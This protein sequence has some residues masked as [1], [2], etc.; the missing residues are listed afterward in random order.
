MLRSQMFWLGVGCSL[1][2]SLMCSG[3]GLL[4]MIGSGGSLAEHTVRRWGLVGRGRSLGP[5]PG[6]S[7]LP[8]CPALLSPLPGHHDMSNMIWATF[9]RQTFPLCISCLEPTDDRLGMRA[10]T[11]L[12]SNFLLSG[13]VLW[14]KEWLKQRIILVSCIEI[15]VGTLTELQSLMLF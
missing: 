15:D 7:C 10:E 5:W 11:K 9:L 12:S 4:K 2:Q 6:R 14:Q 8:S 1:P 3:V 13:I